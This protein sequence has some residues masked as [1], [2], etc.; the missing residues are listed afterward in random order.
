MID[1]DN[2]GWET[3]DTSNPNPTPKTEAPEI[4]IEGQPEA[5]PKETPVV[6]TEP[7]I[8]IEDD[9]EVQEA[10]PEEGEEIKE[11]S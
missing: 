1:N 5:A 11:L 3:I 6:S 7:E 9:N 4:E 8:I 10:P 2:D